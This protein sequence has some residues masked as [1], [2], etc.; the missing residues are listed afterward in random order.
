M[1]IEQVLRDAAASVPTEVVQNV[2]GAAPSSIRNL[3]EAEIPRIAFELGE[4]DKKLQ[5]GAVIADIGGGITLFPMGAIKIGYKFILVDDFADR[6]HGAAAAYLDAQRASGVRVESLD[7][8]HV[9]L[10]FQPDSLD[11]VT[12]FDCIEHLHNSPR[13][14]LKQMMAALKPGGVFFLGVPNCVNLRKRL[15]VPLGIGK[16]SSME[17]WYDE[18]VFRGHV[19]ELDVDDLHY[20]ARDLGL[21]DVEIMGR[22]WLGYNSRFP[23]VKALIPAADRM[24]QMAPSLCSN[25][26]MLAR[27]PN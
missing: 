9:P 26:Y 16:W 21:V 10:P 17:T 1:T 20:I 5:P 4:L 11:A 8:M 14:L 25:L 23:W 6:W 22:N 27:K 19:R 2:S 24:M 18:P 15:T 13:P 3:L 12:S 7:V